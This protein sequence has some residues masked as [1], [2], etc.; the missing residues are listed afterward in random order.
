MTVNELIEKLLRMQAGVKNG[1]GETVITGD[2]QVTMINHRAVPDEF[3]ITPVQDVSVDCFM[4]GAPWV[5]TLE[6]SDSYDLE[7][8]NR[9]EAYLDGEREDF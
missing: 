7:S 9:L 6:V 2:S 8:A 3:W 5:V 4:D 1:I